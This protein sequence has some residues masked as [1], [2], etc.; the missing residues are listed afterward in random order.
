MATI[1]QKKK[2]IKTI[3]N[4]VRY[5]RLNFSRYGG[6]V[7]MGS[8]TKGQYDYWVDRQSEFEE[9]IPQVDFD[10]CFR[11]CPSCGY[12]HLMTAKQRLDFLTG[13][14]KYDA[15]YISDTHREFSYKVPFATQQPA[16]VVGSAGLIARAWHWSY[17]RHGAPQVHG[18][19][20]RMHNRRM[21]EENWASWV[22]MRMVAEALVRFKKDDNEIIKIKDIM[23][24]ALP[25]KIKNKVTCKKGESWG[26]AK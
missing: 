1:E 7:A 17:L 3:K 6:E 24:S 15:V 25:L 2:L 4:P 8:I 14:N 20:E 26:S 18:R 13:S 5:F 23:E 16:A 19:F 9:Y 11:V 21:T 10:A 22:A 12:H